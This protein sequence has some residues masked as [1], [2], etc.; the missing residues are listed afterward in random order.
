MVSCFFNVGSITLILLMV[1]ANG[2]LPTPIEPKSLAKF[3]KTTPNI[4]KK[5]IGEYIAKQDNLQV[6]IEFVKLFDFS[7]KRLDESLRFFLES[8]RLPGESQQIERIMEHFANTYFSFIHGVEGRDIED[9]EST[10]VLSYS[11]VML[12]MDQHNPQVRKKMTFDDFQKNTRGVN[13]GKDFSPIF[14]VLCLI[15]LHLDYI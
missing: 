11:I 7:G 2:F 12:N 6:L 4:N 10:F 15:I 1:K 9:Q 8:F 5:V 13:G 14:L 3:L